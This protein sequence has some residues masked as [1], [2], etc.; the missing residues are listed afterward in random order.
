MLGSRFRG[1]LPTTVSCEL[2]I[3]SAGAF[4][5]VLLSG[6]GGGGG[7]GSVGWLVFGAPSVENRTDTHHFRGCTGEPGNRRRSP[8]GMTKMGFVWNKWPSASNG[9]VV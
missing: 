8:F 5:R 2:T 4:G 3:S 7:R 9:A 6:G 1:K